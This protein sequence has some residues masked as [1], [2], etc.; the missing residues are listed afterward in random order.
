MA[1]NVDRRHFLELSLA[2]G[3]VALV[4]PFELAATV[5]APTEAGTDRWVPTCCR[6]AVGRRVSRHT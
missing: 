2:A 6:C 1:N 4:N 5:G 3:G